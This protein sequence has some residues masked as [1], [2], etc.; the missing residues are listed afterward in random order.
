[1]HRRFRSVVALCAA[2]ALVF[3]ALFA[4][5]GSAR[6]AIP[7][8]FQLCIAGNS[9]DGTAPVHAAHDLCCILACGSGG[10]PALAGGSITPIADS[11]GF[12]V[13]VPALTPVLRQFER[14]S[15]APPRGP[16]LRA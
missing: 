11:L 16:P 7:D 2:Y 8:G 6:A 1:M 12:D 13:S 9:S 3:A 10:P 5:F 15:S 4:A 14:L